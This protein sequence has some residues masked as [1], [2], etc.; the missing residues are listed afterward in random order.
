MDVLENIQVT[1]SLKAIP[2]YK[3]FQQEVRQKILD[4][5]WRPG[6]QLPSERELEE[7][8]KISRLTINKSLNQLADEGLLIRHRG[9]GTFVAQAG[10]SRHDL[11]TGVPAGDRKITILYLSPGRNGIPANPVRWGVLEGLHQQLDPLGVSPAV[12]FYHSPEQYEAAVRRLPD[13]S[14]AAVLW[15]EPSLNPRVLDS[16]RKRK[17]PF[18]LLDSYPKNADVDFVVGDNAAGGRM[19]VEHLVSLGHRRIVY[20]TIPVIRTSTRD[21]QAGFL[22]GAIEANLE[23]SN[24]SVVVLR[25]QTEEDFPA[26]IPR[27]LEE[28]LRRPAPPT[29]ICFS[30]DILAL[31]AIR[32]L[33]EQGIRVPDEIS[34]MGYDNIDLG[35]YSAVPLTTVGQ[36]WME[37]GRSAADVL[38]RKLHGPPPRRHQ[39]IFIPPTLVVR[40]STEKPS[41]QIGK[42]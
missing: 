9:K 23:I 24:A 31:Q 8:Y 39:Q 14:S 2:I 12:D 15:N 6:Q 32:H 29:A 4:G 30:N 20:V 18:V 41:G 7:T 13:I 17:F 5:R 16:L 28:I 19:M 27:V 26:D 34:I 22:Q 11:P 36:H 42:A 1:N 3:R 37:M 38:L 21:R 40:K 10:Q 33:G 25:G 35:E